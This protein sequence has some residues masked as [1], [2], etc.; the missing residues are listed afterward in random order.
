M[1]KKEL[2]GVQSSLSHAPGRLDS[3]STVLALLKLSDALGQM[4]P[5][6]STAP[7]LA[8]SLDLGLVV[9]GTYD[10]QQV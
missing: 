3:P 4:T 9:V 6:A 10:L 7:G 2:M 1:S 8:Q 5:E